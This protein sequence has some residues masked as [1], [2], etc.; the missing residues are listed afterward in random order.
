MAV[1]PPL[2]RVEPWVLRSPVHCGMTTRVG[3]PE[4]GTGDADERSRARSRELLA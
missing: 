2:L 4:A 3:F 1:I